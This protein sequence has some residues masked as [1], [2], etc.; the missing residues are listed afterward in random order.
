MGCIETEKAIYCEEFAC[1]VMEA[2]TSRDLQSASGRP[3]RAD[4]VVPVQVRIRRTDGLSSSSKAGSPKNQE[5]PMCQFG[6]SQCPSLKI[7]RLEE[8]SPFLAGGSACLF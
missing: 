2:E 1:A 6:K 3:R 8:Y 5:Q 7:V 4:S